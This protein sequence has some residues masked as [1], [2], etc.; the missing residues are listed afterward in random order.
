MNAAKLAEY[1]LVPVATCCIEDQKLKIEFTD[2][3]AVKL[4]KCIYAFLIDGKVVR[5]GSSKAPLETRLKNYMR[6][7]TRALN[8]EKSPAPPEEAD[9]WLKKLPAGTS[10]TIYARPGWSVT[11][12]IKTF[13]AYMDE[14]SLL[15]EELFNDRD[16]TPDEILNRNKHR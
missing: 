6:D 13:N 10:G 9:L 7:I 5:I 1:R 15:I 16:L 2:L 14:E 11:T 8:N 3:E 4:E 12:P